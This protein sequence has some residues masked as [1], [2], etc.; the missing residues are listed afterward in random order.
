MHEFGGNAIVT[1]EEIKERTPGGTAA[2]QSTLRIVCEPWSNV[3]YGGVNFMGNDAITGR[4]RPLD[5]SKVKKMSFEFRY[6]RNPE[7]TGRFFIRFKNARNFETG[8]IPIEAE[9]QQG[10]FQIFQFDPSTYSQIVDEINS[11]ERHEFLAMNISIATDF[12]R[13]KWLGNAEIEFQN[14]QIEMK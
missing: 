6:P 1:C 4:F 12:V 14:L 10:S 7:G 13:Y 5:L 2:S 8:F 11:N 9:G 3:G